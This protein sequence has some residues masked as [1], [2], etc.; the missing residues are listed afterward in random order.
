MKHIQAR[1]SE[2]EYKR[3]KKKAVDLNITLEELIKKSLE[4]YISQEEY[5]K[6]VKEIQSIKKGGT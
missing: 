5:F 1:L 4:D 6:A 3:Y 2:D